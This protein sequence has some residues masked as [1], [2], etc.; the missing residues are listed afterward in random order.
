MSLDAQDILKELA[1]RSAA[2]Q[3]AGGVIARVKAEL[4]DK[5]VALLEDPSRNKAALCTRRAGKTST[6]SRYAVIECLRRPGALVRIWAS[7]R[8][9]AK[10]LL[11]GE[12]NDICDRHKIK[13]DTHETELRFTFENRSEIRLVGADKDKEAQKKRG[14]K[15]S[16]EIVLESQ[17]FGPFL[18]KLVEDVIEPSL[19]D[20]RGTV[21]MEGTPGPVCAGYWFH[22]TGTKEDVARWTSTGIEIKDGDAVHISGANWSCHRWSVL[23]NPFLPHAKEELAALKKKR[24][25]AD[26]NPTWLREYQAKWVNDTGALY[27]RWDS[28]RNTYDIG[29]T[30]PW[31]PGWSHV[32]GWDIG[33]ND[34]MALVV[35]GWHEND[36]T[37]YEAYSWA[38]SK[39]LSEAVVEKIRECQQRFNIVKMVADTGGGGRLFVEEVQARYGL[40]FEAAQKQNK[41][42]HVLLMNND[43]LT[44]RIKTLPSSAYSWD[45]ARLPKDPD[46]DPE[47]GRPPAEDPRFDNH[48]TDAGLYG[49]RYAYNFLSEIEEP[50]AKVGTQE[51]TDSIERKMIESLTT[52]KGPWW[53]PTQEFDDEFL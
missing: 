23:D 1:R 5:Q 13:V 4:F 43:F 36:K 51:Y 17:S 39:V 42:E 30:Q 50:E 26:D 25:W 8:L 35:W 24:Q 27:Y 9:R 40:V 18:Q 47:S 33:F 6:W 29:K 19:F 22:V 28:T 21:C 52:P 3:E 16:L 46:W 11:W 32:L 15:T 7:A 31:G 49:F 37:L 14:D 20:T 48:T 53:E 12:L 10:E 45:V 38:E 2:S 34:A 41:Y 44:G